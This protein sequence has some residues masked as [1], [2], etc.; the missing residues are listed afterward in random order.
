MLENMEKKRGSTRRL[1]ERDGRKKLFGWL[2]LLMTFVL[3]ITNQK[4][5][6]QS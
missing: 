6:H 2:T 4:W 3:I 5:F 1:E